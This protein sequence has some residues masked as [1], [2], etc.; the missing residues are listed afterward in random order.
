MKWLKRLL[1]FLV[2]LPLLTGLAFWGLKSH[3]PGES[4]AEWLRGEIGVR[5]GIPVDMSPVEL[6][7]SGIEVSELTVIR[8]PAWEPLPKGPL[9][10]FNQLQIPFWTLFT[11]QI[12]QFNAQSH[13]GMMQVETGLFNPRNLSISMEGIRLEQMPA[14][15]R[16]PYATLAG[17][18]GMELQI[19]NMQALQSRKTTFPEG[20]MEGILL[21]FRIRLLGLGL[22]LP[23]LALSEI[24]LDEVRFDLSLGPML[25]LK[26]VKL[27]GMLAGTISG[28]VQLNPKR[29]DASRV[30]LVVQLTPSAKLRKELE[31][32]ASMLRPFQCGDTINVNVAGPLNRLP[33]PKRRNCG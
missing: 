8:P 32:V 20:R 28:T 23:E 2:F 9:L 19:S 24:R 11:R 21:D 25:N 33:V 6:E 12:L 17:G 26:R 10:V 7:W 16:F 15:A 30:D 18:L 3:F 1:L 4:L 27:A 5:T 13:E 31:S 14:A 29:L 22:L